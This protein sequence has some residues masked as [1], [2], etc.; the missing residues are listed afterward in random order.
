MN[1]L[2]VKYLPAR[3][4]SNT[5]IL[6]NCAKQQINGSHQI[7]E[8]DLETVPPPYF[9]YGILMNYYR[10]NYQGKELSKD[11]SSKMLAMDK[12]VSQLKRADVVILASPMHNFGMPGI[13]KLW[14]D[15]VMQKGVAFDYGEKG[16]IGL[17]KNKKALTIFTSG[18]E[19]SN[20]QVSLNYPEWDTYT[21]LS[22]IEFKFM[23]F[24]QVEVVSAAVANPHNKD[25]NIFAA[26]NKIMQILK[27]W[28]LN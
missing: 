19:Y 20:C 27:D 5:A 6:L 3:E 13:V 8:L 23:G 18:G 14:F 9:D 24:S 16:P 21:F 17:F 2:I 26:K 15:A 4:F 28:K 11:E 22:K 25:K 10:R 1:I 7:E 12:L